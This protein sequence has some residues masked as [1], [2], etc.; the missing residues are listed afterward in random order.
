MPQHTLVCL[1]VCV[2]LSASGEGCALRRCCCRCCCRPCGGQQLQQQQLCVWSLRVCGVLPWPAASSVVL[3]H[4][5]L[6]FMCACVARVCIVCHTGWYQPAWHVASAVLQ[7]RH[8]S[9]QLS[10][11]H[12]PP[13]PSSPERAILGCCCSSH[14]IKAVLQEGVCARVHSL[15][16]WGHCPVDGGGGGVKRCL[17][18]FGVCF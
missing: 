12:V 13:S 4:T 18:F 5:Q 17:P 14:S 11:V 10:L 3:K 9:V 8:S 7:Q 1:C 2:S 16:V 15:S 6:P